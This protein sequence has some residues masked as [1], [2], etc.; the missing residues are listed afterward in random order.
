MRSVSMAF[1]WKRARRNDAA[2]ARMRAA[3]SLRARGQRRI[4]DLLDDLDAALDDDVVR[5]RPRLAARGARARAAA[6]RCSMSPSPTSSYEPSSPS[7]SGVAPERRARLRAA[8]ARGIASGGGRDGGRLRGIDRHRE[9]AARPRRS[10]RASG[11]WSTSSRKSSIL[12]VSRAMRAI[13]FWTSMRLGRLPDLGE[14]LARGG[15]A[16]RGRAG[17]PGSRSA[18]SRA[19][20]CR[21]SA[22]CARG[23][24]RPRCARARDPALWWSSR[25]MTLSASSRRPSFTSCAGGDR[26]LGHGAVG[27]LRARE[28]LGEA[29]VGQRVG[30]IELDD[31]AEDLDGL[32]VAV[33]ALQA[34]RDLVERGERV[35]RQPELLVE[36]G[37]LRRDVRVRLL[38]LRDVLRDDL[39]DL[40]VD[41]DRLQREALARVELADPL[42]RADGVGVRLHLRLEVAD[43]QEG[44]S[45][46]RILLDDL[47]VLDDRLVVLLL[48]DVLLGGGE[49]LFSVNRHG[50]GCSS[51]RVLRRSEGQAGLPRRSAWQ[52]HR[53]PCM[54]RRGSARINQER[55]RSEA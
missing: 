43:L 32:G 25:S 33:L 34:R 35:A 6:R 14:G 18:A 21:R 51:A 36:L 38:E 37:E 47:L 22:G 10:A 3:C 4:A 41:G 52:S 44:P 27:V 31:L 39:A 8:V 48:L 20:A 19:P 15:R 13:S 26:E 11:A 17:W 55:A 30:R 54:R 50:S 2:S 7:S 12:P 23:R 46:V 16:C 9:L 40:L 29:Q 49:Y 28:R 24:A 45:V 5:R 1:A 42:V 53:A